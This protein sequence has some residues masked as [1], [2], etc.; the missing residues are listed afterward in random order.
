MQ[1]SKN[2]RN[3]F[4]WHRLRADVWKN[5]GIYLL[6]ILPVIW[7]AI[8]CYGPMGGLTLAFKKYSARIGMGLWGSPFI[9]LKNFE[10]VFRDKGFLKSVLLTLK[11]NF[12][13]LIVVF[14]FPILIALL[15]NEFRSKHYRK[16][17]QTVITFPHFL[18]WVIVGSIIK[19]LLALRGPVD[20]LI[21]ALGGRSTFILG[22]KSWFLPLIY[23]TVNWKGAGWASIIYL[24]AISSIDQNQY[25]AAEID[26]ASRFQRMIYVTLPSILPTI[27]I[28]LVL[29]IGGMMDGHFD[30][31]FNLRNDIVASAGQTLSI[32]VYDVTFRR[33][34]N[35]GYS[36]AIGLI[37]SIV[38]CVLLITGNTI[39]KRLGGFGIMG[40]GRKI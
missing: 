22:E 3:S 5:R 21:Q 20:V 36:T 10:T 37:S 1:V 26:G 15:L 24:A 7:Y 19:N 6:M 11:I 39:V 28:K 35:Y 34:P 18:S 25:E 8:F 31:I 17:I 40:E 12:T 27:A 29:D 23:A 13:E 2:K 14:P 16:I 33:M 38:N 32:F 30:Q 4:S 9:G